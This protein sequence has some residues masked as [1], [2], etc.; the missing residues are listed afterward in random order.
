MKEDPFAID[1]HY[2]SHPFCLLNS[3]ESRHRKMPLCPVEAGCH[4]MQGERSSW[5]LLCACGQHAQQVVL[6]FNVG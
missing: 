4:G 2:K 3:L 5:F 6:I 1:D